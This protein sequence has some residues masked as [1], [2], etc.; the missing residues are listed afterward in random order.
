MKTYKGH[1]HC[2]AVQYEVALDLD[3]P[4]MECNCSHCSSKGFLL[5]FTGRDQFTL[6]SGEENLTEYTFN[7][8][9][10]SHLFCSICG[11]QCFGF[12]TMPDGTPT[13]AVNVR[14][15]EDIDIAKLEKT[16]VDG[17]NF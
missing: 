6:L 16:P 2:S 17:K 9:V 13:V 8:K 10:I 5:S 3:K 1:C 15:L 7:K 12:G 11:T 14:T 4:V